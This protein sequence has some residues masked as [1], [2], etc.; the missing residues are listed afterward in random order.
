[1]CCTAKCGIWSHLGNLSPKLSHG[2]NLLLPT[3]EDID[4]FEHIKHPISAYWDDFIL[5]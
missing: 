5:R 1:M 4:F 3:V 2:L